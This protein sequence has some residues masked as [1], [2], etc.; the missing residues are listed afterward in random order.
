MRRAEGADRCYPGGVIRVLLVAAALVAAPGCADDCGDGEYRDGEI[1][2]QEQVLEVSPGV[3]GPLALRAADFDGDGADDVLVIGAGG[4]GVAGAL[5]LGDGAGGLA[6]ARDA[7]VG[8]CSAY[9]VA[10]D[11]DADGATDLLFAT[12]AE[13]L[14]YYRSEAGVFLAPIEIAAGTVVRTSVVVDISGDGARD[15]LILGGGA[16]APVLSLLVATPTGF[17]APVLTPIA[18][19]GLPGFDPTTMA[20]GA[21]RRD[22]PRALILAQADRS[23]GLALALAAGAAISPP[24]AMATSLRPTALALRDVDD[25]DALD[26]LVLDAS[27][28]AL[29]P[30]LG[31]DLVEGTRTE[32]GGEPRALGLGHL[33]GDGSVDLAI[34]AGAEVSL[35]RGVGDGRFT[36]SLALRFPSDGFELGLPDLNGDGRADLVAGPFEDE[37]LVVRLSGP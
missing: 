3:E 14:L 19:G 31:P 28:G 5:H 16:G 37:G 33:D 15:L 18:P 13:S 24:A 26:L 30:L 32:V 11:V 25:D 7:A 1:C 21:L 2:L 35:W 29:A 12:C 6:P 4:A 27:R 17:A 10:A 8:G 20:V 9:P 34:V 22:G 36:R 23:G